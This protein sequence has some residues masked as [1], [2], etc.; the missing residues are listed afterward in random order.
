MSRSPRSCWPKSLSRKPPVSG[1]RGC[2]PVATPP[3]RRATMVLLTLLMSVIA[4]LIPL[5]A[6]AQS[7]VSGDGAP[8][9]IDLVDR[10]LGQWLPQYTHH[11][12]QWVAGQPGHRYGVRLVNTTAERLLVVLSIDGINAITGDTAHP[13]QSGYVL[14]PWQSTEISGWRKSM[15]DVA[16]FVFTDLPD[17]Y[18]ARTGRPAN[19]GTIGIAVFRERRPMV[20]APSP[21]IARGQQRY[22]KSRASHPSDA[23][24]AAS[25]M[26][27]QE[28]VAAQRIGTGHGQREWAPVGQTTFD[29]AGTRPVQ[30]L[31]LR[32]DAP[33]A[34]AARGILPRAYAPHP[35]RRHG[36]QAFPDRFVADPPRGRDDYFDR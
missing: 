9:R 8:V 21:P 35:P 14:A 13:A 20:V 3:V 6:H 10:D 23:A 1:P 28:Q 19:V 30:L 12:E 17:S 2:R 32:Y 16:Q 26:Q 11:G 29:R 22:E 31:Q 33:E 18:A 4:A 25:P 15:Q 27:E 7:R 24:A 5:H 34:L 36:P